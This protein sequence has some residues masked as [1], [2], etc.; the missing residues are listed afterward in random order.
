MIIIRIANSTSTQAK[1][2]SNHHE[3]SSIRQ[4]AIKNL[5]CKFDRPAYNVMQF[6]VLNSF[7][8]FTSLDCR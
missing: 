8:D 1:T 7:Q 4:T 2:K 5:H 6:E 3:K